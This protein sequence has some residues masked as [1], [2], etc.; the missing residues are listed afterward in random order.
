MV[1]E[2]MEQDTL[3]LLSLKCH[4]AVVPRSSDDNGSKRKN[5]NPAVLMSAASIQLPKVALPFMLAHWSIQP[6]FWA[7]IMKIKHN[8]LVSRWWTSHAGT[9]VCGIYSYSFTKTRRSARFTEKTLLCVQYV[10]FSL[11]STFL[12]QDMKSGGPCRSCPL[13][14]ELWL[15]LFLF[16]VSPCWMKA[17]RTELSLREKEQL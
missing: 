11:V 9:T 15:F 4:R 6:H 1:I 16:K 14:P 17:G 3:N 10:L 2:F 8:H 13:C 12:R 7:W 5:S